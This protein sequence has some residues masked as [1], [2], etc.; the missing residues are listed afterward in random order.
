MQRMAYCTWL[1]FHV[2]TLFSAHAMH[3]PFNDSDNRVVAKTHTSTEQKE[4]VGEAMDG[5][6]F[7]RVGIVVFPFVSERRIISSVD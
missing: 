4:K 1:Q 6:S 7:V 3:V 2:S 5:G